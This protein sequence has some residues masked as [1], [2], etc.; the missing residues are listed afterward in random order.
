MTLSVVQFYHFCY[1][2][3]VQSDPGEPRS[4]KQAMQSKEWEWWKKAITSEI[5]NFL[6]RNAWEFVK[7]DV[8]LA[9][10]R[11]PIPTKHVFY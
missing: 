5:N 4:F 1:N 9:Q 7:K 3:A 6:K 10:G 11:Q 8:V 2:T